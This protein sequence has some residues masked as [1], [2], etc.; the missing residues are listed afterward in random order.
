MDDDVPI[1]EPL[2]VLLHRRVAHDYTASAPLN[3]FTEI[4]L[5]T[6]SHGSEDGDDDAEDAGG[7]TKAPP[8]GVTAPDPVSGDTDV[9]RAVYYSDDGETLRSIARKFGLNVASLVA[10]N[11]AM[12]H[13]GPTADAKLVRDTLV[14]LKVK[15]LHTQPAAH[16]RDKPSVSHNCD[17]DNGGGDGD[18]Q[19]VR[20]RATT[21]PQ[22]VASCFLYSVLNNDTPNILAK[23][24]GAS[25][26]DIIAIN[27]WRYRVRQEQAACSV[28]NPVN[29]VVIGRCPRPRNNTCVLANDCRLGFVARPH[30]H[31]MAGATTGPHSE[32]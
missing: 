16:A 9:N 5:P 3:A 6:Q 28:A 14:Y 26:S 8:L 19:V 7:D 25:P 18:F 15:N 30:P 2:V 4:T 13:H 17:S 12:M 10:L 32:R 21:A 24:F 31:A 1:W 20:L 29:C 11:S 27:S 23:R 22:H